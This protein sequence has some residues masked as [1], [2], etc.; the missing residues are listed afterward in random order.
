M[1]YLTSLFTLLSIIALSSCGQTGEQESKQSDSAHEESISKQSDYEKENHRPAY[2]RTIMPVDESEKDEK[3]N[4]QL[5]QLREIILQKD[6]SAL[7]RMMDSNIVSSHGGAI[8]G[9]EGVKEV[10]KNGGLWEKLDQIIKLGGVF[11]KDGKEFR[12]PYCQ[13]SHLYGSWGLDWYKAGAVIAPNTLLYSEAD[14]A[15]MVMDTLHYAIVE[16][17]N[18][19]GG[20]PDSGMLRVKPVGQPKEGY[21]RYS[22][23]YSTSDY[24]LIFENQ[25]D[26]NWL[27]TSFAPYD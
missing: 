14:T 20:E 23:F 5:T 7:F 1:K 26:G 10:W 13:D 25:P 4:K 15:S 19:Y 27:I 11:D 9:Y 8:Y 21:I 16:T 12:L 2:P 24:M 6:T 3:L 22:K 17:M 18:H